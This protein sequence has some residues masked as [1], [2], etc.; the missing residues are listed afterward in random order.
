LRW[1][2]PRKILI[3]IY[4]ALVE[5]VISYGIT[6]WGWAS[7]AHIKKIEY[8]LDRIVNYIVGEKHNVLIKE[9]YISLKSTE[10]TIVIVTLQDHNK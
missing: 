5:S 4:H 3:L 1:Y 8:I 10:L 6:I 9:K 2:V 7:D